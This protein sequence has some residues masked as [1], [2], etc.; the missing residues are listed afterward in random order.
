MFN[1]KFQIEYENF[2]SESIKTRIEFE[3]AAEFS[4][5]RKNILNIDDSCFN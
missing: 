2:V 1:P 3:Q 5:V 4:L